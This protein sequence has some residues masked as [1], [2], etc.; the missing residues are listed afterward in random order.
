MQFGESRTA[1]LLVV[2]CDFNQAAR[3]A[4][5]LG[6]FDQRKI[7]HAAGN[8]ANHQQRRNSEGWG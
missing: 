2:I 3:D 6:P 8:I 4:M 5:R 1:Q 7:S